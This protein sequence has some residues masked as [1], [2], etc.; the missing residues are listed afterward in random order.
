MFYFRTEQWMA[1]FNG[2][3]Q[4]P[5]V[6]A[7]ATCGML[8]STLNELLPGANAAGDMCECLMENVLTVG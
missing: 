6:V 7:S 5:D 3:Y 1:L 8:L 2:E 4:E